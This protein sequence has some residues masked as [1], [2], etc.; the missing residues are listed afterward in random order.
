MIKLPIYHRNWRKM[1]LM[2]GSLHYRFRKR[3]TSF[4]VDWEISPGRWR[5][6]SRSC[7]CVRLIL[8]SI[9]IRKNSWRKCMIVRNREWKKDCLLRLKLKFSIWRWWEIRRDIR[10][11]E[12]SECK[13][14]WYNRIILPLQPRLLHNKEPTHTFLTR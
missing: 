7:R 2:E 12:N 4:R 5:R 3:S 13:N 14:K 6:L 9:R 10:K 8:S 1:Q 11:K